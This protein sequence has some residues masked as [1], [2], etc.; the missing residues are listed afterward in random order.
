MGLFADEEKL[1][2]LAAI[3]ITALPLT[4]C[5]GVGGTAEPGTGP[6]GATTAPSS[7]DSAK[8]SGPKI[9]DAY[10]Y[11]DGA[12]VEITHTK[13]AKIGKYA[14]GGKPGGSMAVITL[15]VTNGTSEAMSADLINVTLSY[16]PDGVQADRVFD[17]DL[18]M[19]HQGTIAKGKAKTAGYA[20]AVPVKYLG[21]VAI[22][23]TPGTE[24]EPVVFTGKIS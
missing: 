5:L 10:K 9:G 3:T 11:S 16:G 23:V 18:G 4:A 17:G 15:R 8:D 7:K 12:V 21:D 14:A 1:A 13:R 24:Y 20:F 6:A 2:A 22:E 19:G